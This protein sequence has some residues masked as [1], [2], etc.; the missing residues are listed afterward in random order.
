MM[1]ALPASLSALSLSAASACHTHAVVAYTYIYR[2][3][4]IHK[5]HTRCQYLNSDK[6]DSS[7]SVPSAHNIII[8]TGPPLVLT[9]ETR[10]QLLPYSTDYSKVLMCHTIRI[11]QH[12]DTV[13]VEVLGFVCDLADQSWDL[14]AEL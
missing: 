2:S 6:I 10:V 5:P 14:K 1:V 11:F 4:M 12:N 8:R 13:P 3:I 9:F 7:H